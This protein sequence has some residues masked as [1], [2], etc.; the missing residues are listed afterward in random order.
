MY[1]KQYITCLTLN[2]SYTHIHKH[3]HFVKICYLFVS[4]LTFHTMLYLIQIRNQFLTQMK[5][6]FMPLHFTF[7]IWGLFLSRQYLVSLSIRYSMLA[8]YL[9]INAENTSTSSKCIYYRNWRKH[10]K[11]SYLSLATCNCTCSDMST[12]PWQVSRSSWM[13]TR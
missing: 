12:W 6:I 8:V 9:K 11:I 3:G 13:A 4:I 5:F 7:V 2:I 1:F 10:F